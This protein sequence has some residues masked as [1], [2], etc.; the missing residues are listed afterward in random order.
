MTSP[1]HIEL[2]AATTAT[3][4]HWSAAIASDPLAVPEQS[5]EWIRAITSSGR[6]RDTSRAYRFA[7]DTTVVLPLVTVRSAELWSPPPA[8]GIG[9]TVGGPIDVHKLT[10]I[11][12]DVRALRAVRVSVRID[13]R[14]ED[15]WRAATTPDDVSLARRSH[16]IDMHSSPD[17]HLAALG[18]SSRYQIR[19]A[20]KKGVQVEVNRTGSLLDEHYGLF[21]LS[22]RR[23]AEKQREPHWLAIARA[24]R[25]DPIEKLRTMQRALGDRMITVVGSV[26]GRPA[27]SAVVLLGPTTRYVRGAMDRDVA[28]PT[29]AAYGVQWAAIQAAY[30][31]G[32]K[33]YHMGES[34]ESDGIAFFKEQ[35]G[36]V[37]VDHHEYRFERIPLTRATN[38]AKNVVKRAIGF[39]DA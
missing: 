11:V 2:V 32:S 5:P 14:F 10:Q 7:D 38:A 28:S 12:A 18:K 13:A 21:L 16:I 6:H 25:R 29:S 39:V 27:A 26:D 9:G 1:S 19:R 31:F 22:V 8:W 17:E 34:G 35:F 24:Q 4:A 15:I 36:A 3:S 23:W 30:E 20:A 33:R 37:P